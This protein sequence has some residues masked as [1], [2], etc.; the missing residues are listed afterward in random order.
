LGVE[1]PDHQDFD[2][3]VLSGDQ[4]LFSCAPSTGLLQQLLRMIKKKVLFFFPQNLYPPQTGAHR[5]CLEMLAGLREIGYEVTL[6]SS[7]LSSPMKWSRSSKDALEAHWVKRV[8]KYETTREDERFLDFLSNF[9]ALVREDGHHALKLCRQKGIAVWVEK[10]AQRLDTESIIK[11]LIQFFTV[12]SLP[13]WRISRLLHKLARLSASGEPPV[14][15][16]I[17]TPPGF[18]RWFNSLVDEVAPDVLITSYARWDGLVDHSRLRSVVR[19]IDY[20][21]PISLNA[22]LQRALLL[23]LP[24]SFSI[25]ATDSRVLREDF[26]ESLNL[27]IDAD[28]FRIF[29]AYD[30]TIAINTREAE[31]I[32]QNARNTKVWIIPVTLEPV[33]VPNQYTGPALFPVGPNPFNNQGYLYFAK[34]VLPQVLI[35]APSFCLDVTGFFFGNMSPEPVE[36]IMVRGFVPNLTSLYELARFV[37]CPV[38]GGTGQQIKIVEAMAHGVPVIALRAAAASSPIVN[39]VNGLVAN[40]AEEFAECVLRLWNDQQLCRQMGQA[41]RDTVASQYSRSR[42]VKDLS[43]MIESWSNRPDA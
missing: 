7:D 42:L 23:C 29:D 22:A 30:Y 36:G 21:D 39:E 43:Q 18:R 34:K 37:V 3:T 16:M 25:E 9:Y 41:A 40:N 27:S 26:F 4:F 5:R 10:A 35:K 15:S 1:I 20:L 31:Q 8:H 12:V 33:Y 2:G 28:E 19:I 32:K 14:G 38:F 17:H 24:A 6:V 11:N 13:D